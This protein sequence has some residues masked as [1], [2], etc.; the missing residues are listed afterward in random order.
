MSG[1]FSAIFPHL[2]LRAFSSGYD[3]RIGTL[4]YIHLAHGFEVKLAW[5]TFATCFP[6]S[7][8][9]VI[10]H[11]G[12]SWLAQSPGLGW[13]EH[14]RSVAFVIRLWDQLEAGRRNQKDH[15]EPFNERR[16]S[17]KTGNNTEEIDRCK[18]GSD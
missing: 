13:C 2:P 5:R 8:H 12:M 1:S 6:T 14:Q 16:R 17:H 11:E 15:Q 4:S 3:F 10:Y 9:P 18:R 7:R